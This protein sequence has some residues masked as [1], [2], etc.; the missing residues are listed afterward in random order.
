M[1][2]FYPFQSC[3]RRLGVSDLQI[4]ESSGSVNKQHERQIIE[5]HGSAP[6]LKLE[7]ICKGNSCS[8]FLQRETDDFC[9]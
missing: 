2:Y 3:S 5:Y 9:C 8:L 6:F 1:A 7:K 4:F